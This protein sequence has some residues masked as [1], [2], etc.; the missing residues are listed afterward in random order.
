VGGWAEDLKLL[1]DAVTA[2]FDDMNAGYEA[3]ATWEFANDIACS[4]SKFLTRFEAIFTLN[5]DLL[6]ERHYLENSPYLHR[7]NGW[8]A[9]AMPGIQSGHEPRHI[10]FLPLSCLG[11]SNFT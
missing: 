5:Q 7:A 2:M 10:W 9:V 1:S 4:V 11:E 8:D 3:R 6:V